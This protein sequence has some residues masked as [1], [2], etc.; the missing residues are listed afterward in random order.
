MVAAYGEALRNGGWGSST[1]GLEELRI[2][3]A[4][5]NLTPLFQPIV[6]LRDGAIIGYEGL[7]RGPSQSPLHL[8]ASLFEV[9]RGAGLSLDVEMLCRNIALEGF[10]SLGLEGRLFLNV[11]PTV[12]THPGFEH[13]KTL[14][15]M[16]H[17]GI[18]PEQ[19]TIEITEHE[20]ISDVRA[21][22][23]ALLHYRRM[24][25]RVALDDLGDGFSSLRLW[26]ELHPEF[27][28]IDKYFVQEADRNPLK[29]Q[30]LI[31]FQQIA[32]NSGCQII[33]EGIETESEFLAVKD[34][35]IA[36]GQGYFF[37]RPG[38][39]P[40]RSLQ[41]M[42]NSVN[43]AVLGSMFAAEALSKIV[44]PNSGKT[45][46]PTRVTAYAPTSTTVTS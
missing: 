26:H 11:S 40:A 43:G 3:I 27:V 5:R 31:S 25:F 6:D 8:P 20:R 38:T 16:K 14:Q 45:P 19:V 37:S 35:G 12:L 29:R 44:S 24:G 34:A 22:R 2:T 15:Y 7:I 9:A 32:S 46:G 30:F 28:K 4:K 17:L 18:R 36:L 42:E 41:E 23:D 21:M 39:A 13:G 33:A 10:A 1:E